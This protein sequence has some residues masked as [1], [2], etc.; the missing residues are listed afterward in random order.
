MELILTPGGDCR[1]LPSLAPFSD[2]MVAVIT[3]KKDGE[4]VADSSP[5][6]FRE[7][8]QQEFKAIK[9]TEGNVREIAG[10][11]LKSLGGS[12]EIDE[13]SMKSTIRHHLMKVATVGDW[14]VEEWDFTLDRLSFR[15]ATVEERKLRNLR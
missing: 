7:V 15:V 1:S 3:G 13:S 5:F 9:V 11:I 14:L 2:E 12:V 8:V 10:Y 6:R 4:T